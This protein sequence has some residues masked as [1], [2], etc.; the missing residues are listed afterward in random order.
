M[1]CTLSHIWQVQNFELLQQGKNV[2]MFCKL[3][4]KATNISLPSEIQNNQIKN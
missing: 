3:A 1:T 4:T 2:N